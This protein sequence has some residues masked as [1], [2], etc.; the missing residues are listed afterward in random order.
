MSE[1]DPP[2]LDLAQPA[3]KVWA[4]PEIQDQSIMSTAAKQPGTPEVTSISYS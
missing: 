2:V 3:K 4:T 1:L